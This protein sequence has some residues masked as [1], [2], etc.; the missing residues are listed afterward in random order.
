MLDGLE[1]LAALAKAGTMGAAGAQLRVSQSA[2]SKRVAALEDVVGGALVERDGRRVALTPRAERLLARALPAVAAMRSALEDEEAPG[3]G[4]G[5][6]LRGRVTLGVSESILASW[7]AGVLKRLMGRFPGVELTPHAHRSPLVIERVAAGEFG[8]GLVAGAGLGVSSGGTALVVEEVAREPMAFLRAGPGKTR[9]ARLVTI[10]ERSG[11]W[12]AIARPARAA[13]L[14][15]TMRVESF[16]AAA[17]LAR[18]GVGDALIPVGV[19]SALKTPR[20]RLKVFGPRVL[21]RPISVIVRRGAA[22]RTV[23]DA[24]RVALAQECA[25]LR[26]D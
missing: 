21:A 14:E 18:A 24:V 12:E 1:A 7:G 3:S 26:W 2:I 13:G 9:A 23:V 8:V 17:A 6:A 4:E 19:A 20:E 5:R 10:E 25:A 22:G 15:P 11:T 16:F